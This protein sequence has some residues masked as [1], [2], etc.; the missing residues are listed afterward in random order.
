MIDVSIINSEQ[1]ILS[2]LVKTNDWGVISRNA[3]ILEHFIRF[4]ELAKI[5]FDYHEQTGK[6]ISEATLMGMTGEVEYL[7]LEDGF[8][9]EDEEDSTTKSYAGYGYIL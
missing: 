3:L 1:Q 2:K 4:P 8:R 9:F 5:I 6:V 7:F